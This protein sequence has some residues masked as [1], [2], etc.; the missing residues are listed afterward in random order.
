MTVRTQ[1]RYPTAVVSDD[2][3]G[4]LAWTTPEEAEAADGDYAEADNSASGVAAQTEYLKATGFG[5]SFASVAV[6]LGRRFDVTRRVTGGRAA[7]VAFVESGTVVSN[8]ITLPKPEVVSEGDILLLLAIQDDNSSFNAPNFVQLAGQSTTGR[9]SRAFYRIAT[10]SEPDEYEVAGLDVTTARAQLVVVRNGVMPAMTGFAWSLTHAST[11]GITVSTVTSEEDNALLIGMFQRSVTATWTE[12]SEMDEYDESGGGM[13]CSELLPTAGATGSRTATS[14]TSANEVAGFIIAVNPGPPGAV[15]ERVSLVLPDGSVGEGDRAT[16]EA[17][18]ES[19]GAAS[20]GGAADKWDEDSLTLEDIEDEDSGLVVTAT[21]AAGSTAGIDAVAS[22]VTVEESL[23]VTPTGPSTF[24]APNQTDTWD[25]AFDGSPATQASY[26]YQ[27]RGPLP[28]T[29]LAYDSG[30]VV[31]ASGSH[32]IGS[33]APVVPWAAPQGGATYQRII[34]V[35]EDGSA[36]TD[37]V[38]DPL[39]GVSQDEITTDWTLPTA[40][41][42]LAAVAVTEAP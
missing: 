30:V 16:S 18:P 9:S 33:G 7:I 21:V 13:A 19:P 17:W 6:P 8:T 14:S 22:V 12:P 32:E 41:T 2:A 37:T 11:A 26:R 20:Y 31:S 28:A 5:H 36:D 42:G 15:D 3:V 38:G 34:T 29:T 27:L 24:S 39:S 1:T 10:D 35:T 25:V 4:T 40:P 23:E